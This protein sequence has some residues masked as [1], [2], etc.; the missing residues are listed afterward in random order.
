MNVEV[1]AYLS[2]LRA[3]PLVKGATIRNRGVHLRTDGGAFALQPE[4]RQHTL[5]RAGLELVLARPRPERHLLLAPFV[6][7]DLARELEAHRVNYLDLAG[8]CHIAL[9][10]KYVA[11]VEGRRPAPAERRGRGLGAAGYRA[12]FALLARPELVAAP[13]RTIAQ[14]AGVAKTGVA[15]LLDRLIAEGTIARAAK[16][17]TL[18]RPERLLERWVAGYA[19]LLRPKLAVGRYRTPEVDPPRLEARITEALAGTTWAWGGGAAAF[20][21]TRHYR[22][23]DTLVHVDKP[24]AELAQALRALPDRNG[25]LQVA[26]VP[27][28][29][30]FEAPVPHVAHPFLVYADLLATGGEREREAA[31]EIRE[32]YLGL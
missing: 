7:A 29:L 3:L 17:R 13:I 11:H 24:V 2:A 19:D 28:P 26:L 31:A 32:R 10:R 14:A 20:R 4:V 27:G 6:P 9:G 22:G 21:L 8:N 1:N 30:A 23:E 12:L 16:G 25:A 15:H 5:N 18:V